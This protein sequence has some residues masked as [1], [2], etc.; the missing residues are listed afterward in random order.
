MVQLRKLKKQRL[1]FYKSLQPIYSPALKEKIYFTSEGFKHLIYE[2]SGSPRVS[3]EQYLKLMYLKYVPDIIQECR[4]VSKIR[5][6]KSNGIKWF[7]LIH[8]AKG[9]GPVRVVVKRM[10]SGKFV[11]VSVMPHGRSKKRR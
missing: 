7:E 2:S 5:V 3:A 4:A 10:V 8:K 9:F 6:D 11:F 1:I